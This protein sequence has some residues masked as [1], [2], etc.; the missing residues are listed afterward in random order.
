MATSVLPPQ[1][2]PPA[3][4]AIT[5][6]ALPLFANFIMSSLYFALVPQKF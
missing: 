2:A 5:F 4:P 3:P 6:I 1:L